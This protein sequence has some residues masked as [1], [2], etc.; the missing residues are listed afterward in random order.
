VIAGL[1]IAQS[2]LGLSFLNPADIA[3]ELRELTSV[4]RYSSTGQGVAAVT[5]VFVSAGRFGM[6]IIVMVILA[7]GAQAYL[8]LRRGKRAAWGFLAL[9]V[10]LVAAMQSGSRGSI[11]FSA[12]SILALSAGFLWGAPWHWAQGRRLTKAVRRGLLVG[13]A[14]LSL[15]VILFPQTMGSNWLYFADTLSPTGPRSEL[16]GRGWD[17]PVSNLLATFQSKTWIYGQGTG[18]SSLGM[19]YVASVLHQPASPPGVESG[20]GTLVTEMGIL[21]PILWFIM[22]GSLLWHAWKAV[23]RV[24]Q[25]IYFPI[26]LSIFWYAFLMLIPYIYMGMAN[27]Q[28]YVTNAYFW[29]LIGVLFRLPHLAHAKE[30]V[31]PARAAAPRLARVPV[32]VGGR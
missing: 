10:A 25:T 19:Q 2:I 23:K 14:G 24:R 9:A 21:G 18:T 15:M 3:P 31:A 28:N 32:Y 20:I 30:V 4:V 11:S 5:S 1:G 17:Y 13:A 22:A 7:M 12:I 29:L 8:L 26:A 16:I 27:Y 6:Y